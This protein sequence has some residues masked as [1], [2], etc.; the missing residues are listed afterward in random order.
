M[1]NFKPLTD[2]AKLNK[3][4]ERV[5]LKTTTLDGTLEQ[6]LRK[7]SVPAARFEEMAVLNGMKL[8]DQIKKGTML[9]VIQ[10]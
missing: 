9:K 5:R 4:A 2:A 10:Q 3:K 1:Q 8:G 6:T 7:L